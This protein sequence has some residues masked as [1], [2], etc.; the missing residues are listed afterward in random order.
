MTLAIIMAGK[1]LTVA[2]LPTT[3]VGLRDKVIYIHSL[4]SPSLTGVQ[5][6]ERFRNIAQ[7]AYESEPGTTKYAVMTPRPDDG[8]T[9]WMV[10]E[11]ASSSLSLS[12]ANSL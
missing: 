10:E 6:V 9:V 8:K 4:C 12:M 5:L 7:S 2:K 3:D 11:W 1:L